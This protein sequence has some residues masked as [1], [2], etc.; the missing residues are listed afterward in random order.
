MIRNYC[1]PAE[2][3]AHIDVVPVDYDPATGLLDLADLARQAL[4]PHRR[5]LPRDPVLPRR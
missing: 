2:M 5:C 4:D 1:E 3:A